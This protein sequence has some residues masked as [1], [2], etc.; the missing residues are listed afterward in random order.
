M[1]ILLKLNI[2]TDM[3]EESKTCVCRD[4]TSKL[5]TQSKIKTLM[6]IHDDGQTR[7]TD[8]QEVCVKDNTLFKIPHA[9]SRAEHS[10]RA[11]DEK[12]VCAFTCTCRSVLA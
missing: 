2:H 4:V 5:A 12:C 9:A 11:G 1:D 6:Q 7:Q 3:T 8:T 10:L